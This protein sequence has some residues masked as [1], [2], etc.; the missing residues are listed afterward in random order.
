[1]QEAI[2]GS[3]QL[4]SIPTDLYGCNGSN[5]KVNGSKSR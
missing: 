1:M 2:D 3:K 5:A 4:F